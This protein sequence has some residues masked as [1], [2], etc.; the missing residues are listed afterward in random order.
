MAAQL[1]TSWNK[2]HPCGFWLSLEKSLWVLL[3]GRLCGIHPLGEHLD[4]IRIIDFFLFVCLYNVNYICI[5]MIFRFFYKQN[6][7]SQFV[8]IFILYHKL[9]H[10]L[11]VPLQIYVLWLLWNINPWN[12]K[13]ID[14]SSFSCLLRCSRFCMF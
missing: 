9:K 6:N 2:S 8:S 1:K 3:C 7:R 14:Q 11:Q 10:M 5:F 13:V 4:W 12:D